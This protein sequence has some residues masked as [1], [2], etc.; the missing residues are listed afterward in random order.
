M[1]SYAYVCVNY[2]QSIV[3]LSGN[4]LMEGDVVVVDFVK[5]VVEAVML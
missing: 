5:V 3:Q 1:R 2:P 4:I